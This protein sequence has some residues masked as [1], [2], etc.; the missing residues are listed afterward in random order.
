MGAGVSSAGLNPGKLGVCLQAGQALIQPRPVLMLKGI[1]G[2][3]ENTVLLS[4]E[5]CLQLAL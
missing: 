3:G 4:S 1:S 5:A 2:R